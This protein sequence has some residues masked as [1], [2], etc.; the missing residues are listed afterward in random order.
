VSFGAPGPK[1]DPVAFHFATLLTAAVPA[2]ARVVAPED[3]SLWLGTLHDAPYPVSDRSLYMK[4]RRRLL[5]DEEVA[6]RKALT[7]F[8]ANPVL[9]PA[10]LD[11]FRDGLRAY[12]VRAIMLRPLPR[13]GPLRELLRGEDFELRTKS[14]I[15][16]LWVRS[17]R[18]AR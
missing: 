7:R 10:R 12:D 1:V 9:D 18:T 6:R 3:V 16:D 14:A 15:L 4:V 13:Y 5:G 8:A 2:N 17:D 11:A